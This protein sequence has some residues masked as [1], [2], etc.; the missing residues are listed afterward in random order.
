MYEPAIEEMKGTFGVDPKEADVR[1]AELRE[2]YRR[3]GVRGSWEKQLEWDREDVSHREA[4]AILRVCR[5]G[6]AGKLRPRLPCAPV[7]PP[8][9]TSASPSPDIPA[10]R[11]PG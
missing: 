10:L 8:D 2:T 3:T 7:S 6:Y 1:V 9:H 5:E 4:F 11:A